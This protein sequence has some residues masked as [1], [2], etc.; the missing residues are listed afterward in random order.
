MPFPREQPWAWGERGRGGGRTGGGGPPSAGWRRGS[1]HDPLT[2]FKNEPY[3]LRFSLKNV[4][5]TVKLSRLHFLLINPLS[6]SPPGFSTLSLA[7]QMSLLQSAWMEILILRV[8]YRSLSFEDKVRVT[9]FF[10]PLI[11]LF[12]VRP[13]SATNHCLSAVGVRRGLHHGR[14]PVEAR[15]TARPE[16]RHPAAGQE[17]PDDETGEGGIRHTQGHRFG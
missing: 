6:L 16:Q 12:I 11:S 14:G 7:D 5:L 10:R 2:F 15:W 9:F 17:I 3:F 1:D 4:R 8:V 13:F